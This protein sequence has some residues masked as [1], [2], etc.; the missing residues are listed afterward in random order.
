MTIF[1]FKF[2]NNGN[3]LVLMIDCY[4]LM[5]KLIL[6]A[7][8]GN[9]SRVGYFRFVTARSGCSIIISNLDITRNRTLFLRH[10][11]QRTSLNFK[12][13]PRNNVLLSVLVIKEKL[14]LHVCIVKVADTTEVEM[15]RNS[16]AALHIRISG[17]EV[18]L[19]RK[20]RELTELIKRLHDG[21][22]KFVSQTVSSQFLGAA[23]SSQ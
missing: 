18:E 20:D 9:S 10:P 5:P 8:F 12:A 19:A 2:N 4:W 1:M 14:R 23:R 21:K 11:S 13:A 3:K 7:V 15:L 22:A 17:L 6:S 16:N